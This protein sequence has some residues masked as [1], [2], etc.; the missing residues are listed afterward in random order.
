[1]LGQK[2]YRRHQLNMKADEEGDHTHN[3]YFTV[4]SK[5]DKITTN[6]KV[7]K[8]AWEKEKN[9]TVKQPQSLQAEFSDTSYLLE[10][11][12]TG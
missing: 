5:H 10:G 2:F 8:R 11:P 9:S 7:V 6:R 3:L 12:G 1:M 4:C